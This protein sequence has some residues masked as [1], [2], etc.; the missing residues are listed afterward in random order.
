MCLVCLD[1]A[2]AKANDL[3]LSLVCF[4]KDDEAPRC[5]RLLAGFCGGAIDIDDEALDKIG[6]AMVGDSHVG[7]ACV[8]VNDAGDEV[9]RKLRELVPIIYVGTL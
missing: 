2:T 5:T 1:L 4:G 8:Q 9:Q 7:I 3:N 6:V